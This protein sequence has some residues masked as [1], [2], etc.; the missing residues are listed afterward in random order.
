M[1]EDLLQFIRG[2]I[3]SVWALEILL[4]MRAR[5]DR[6]WTREELARELRSHPNLTGEILAGFERAGLLASRPEGCAYAPASEV[7][8]KLSGRLADVYRERPVTVINAI[9]SSRRD[10]LQSF[11]DAFRLRGDQKK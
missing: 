6:T 7:L 9:T 5:R 11:A 1:D 3:P 4:L 10:H 8:D 2:V